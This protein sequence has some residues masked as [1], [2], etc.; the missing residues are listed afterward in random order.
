MKLHL[1]EREIPWEKYTGRSSKDLID[2]R[3]GATSGFSIGLAIYDVAD[4]YPE[5]Q[6][7]DDQEALYIISGTGWLKVG[8]D[9]VRLEP[10][11]AV[12]VGPEVPHAARADGP[13][14]VKALYSHGA[15]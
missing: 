3:Q 2:A 8:D 6:A 15:I 12:Y 10:G 1:N 13:E 4:E 11:V 9:D 7:H 5:P 14:P